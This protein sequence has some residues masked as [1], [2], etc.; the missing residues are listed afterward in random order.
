V[1]PTVCDLLGL[2]VKEGSFIGESFLKPVDENRKLY[3]S[4]WSNN[5]CLGMRE[6]RYKYIFTKMNPLPEIYDNYN[7]PE[8]KENLFK[9]N[10]FEQIELESRR[11]ELER[12]ALVECQQYKEWRKK[13]EENLKLDRKE[14]FIKTIEANF[15]DLVSAYGF[16]IFLEDTEPNRT[17]SV[18][19]GFRIE[20]KIKKPLRLMAVFKHRGNGQEVMRTLSPR[21]VLEK[22]KPGDYTSAELIFVVPDDWPAGEV[23]VYFGV[24]DVKKEEYIPFKQNRGK[25]E[26]ELVF[27]T[28]LRIH[29]A[30]RE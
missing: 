13:A 6:G 4:G 3:F 14:D 15:S 19:V 10:K 26:A 1:P 16:G 2:K 22:L 29:T 9:S 5:I 11:Q 7:D 12:W 20:N 27:L 17:A 21:I 25:K 18:R 30:K 28:D 8:D 24:L 23:A